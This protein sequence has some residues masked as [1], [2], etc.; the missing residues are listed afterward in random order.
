MPNKETLIQQ[1]RL[2]HKQAE[3]M[4]R[5]S[6]E[7]KIRKLEQPKKENQLSTCDVLTKTDVEKHIQK[8]ETILK[9][10]QKITIDEPSINA[11]LKPLKQYSDAKVFL[12]KKSLKNDFNCYKVEHEQVTAVLKLT[13]SN[14]D[15]DPC[16]NANVIEVFV[17]RKKECVVKLEKEITI[18]LNLK[19]A[20]FLELFLSET[21]ESHK[22]SSYF[23]GTNLPSDV[24]ESI[25]GNTFTRI[26][27][28]IIPCDF[29]VNKDRN[30]IVDFTDYNFI[31]INF[32]LNVRD[33]LKRS[34]VEIMCLNRQHHVLEQILINDAAMC[35]VCKD[36]IHV[37]DKAFC[38]SFCRVLTHHV[39]TE[40]IFFT[41]KNKHKEN[42]E[43]ARANFNIPHEL[44]SKT[45]TTEPFCGHCGYKIEIGQ[46]EEKCTRCDRTFHEECKKYV[47]NSC[48]I[49]FEL[50]KQLCKF[51]QS[52]SL[53]SDH[54]MNIKS[55]DE[56][57]IFSKIGEGAFS[58]V[59]LAKNIVDD[60]KVAL[61]V[62]PKN[63]AVDTVLLE[64]EK[65]ILEAVTR[66]DSPFTNKLLYFYQDTENIYF[67]LEYCSGGDLISLFSSEK[68]IINSEKLIKQYACEL[69]IAIAVI[70]QNHIIYRDLKQDNILLHE[71]GHIKLTDFGLSKPNMDTNALAFTFC[72][73]PA[74]M[75]PEVFQQTGYDY[76]CDF[77]SLGII[78]YEM[79]N[80]TQPF[81]APT[82][83]GLS[84]KILK[85]E[86]VFT[87]KDIS[88]EA[89]DFIVQL[90]HKDPAER[91]GYGEDGIEKIKK[92]PWVS[93]VN[94]DDIIHAKNEVYYVP[95]P[96]YV[97]ENKTISMD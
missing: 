2:A 48:G 41:C 55:L 36:K 13:I 30:I 75:A 5:D 73:T 23:S 27:L 62:I 87:N 71:S 6:L 20:M 52:D 97:D 24:L 14:I 70:H 44:K 88:A 29:F 54:L 21:K 39:C 76:G 68:S 9:S 90:T 86:L 79:F 15:L 57:K 3:G 66:F 32:R 51:A 19:N 1:L 84:Q 31:S 46:K 95:E 93:D 28:A 69:I 74:L 33:S 83:K 50:R 77:W 89:K 82:I 11:A 60:V 38:C 47:F 80:K 25:S 96:V 61:K 18:H 10:Y 94:W 65:F 12:L 34:N 85:D 78:L 53:L 91:L 4:L 35:N 49:T 43:P 17:D 92:H 64:R 67:G 72:G 59:Y 26:G 81:T 8:E 7:H 45:S 40:Q 37:F 42:N 63:S 22:T 58:K 56:F 16:R